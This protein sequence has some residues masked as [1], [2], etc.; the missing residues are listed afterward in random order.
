[1][2]GWDG[3]AEPPETYCQQGSGDEEAVELVFRLRS[4]LAELAPVGDVDIPQSRQE[5]EESTETHD[6]KDERGFSWVETEVACVHDWDGFSEEIDEADDDR[7]NC[8]GRSY[9]GLR[10]EE[11]EG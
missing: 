9:D 3:G 5:K 1:M 8:G 7:S 2:D 10:G 4:L 11:M 6:E